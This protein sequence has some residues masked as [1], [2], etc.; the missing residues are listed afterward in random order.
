[1]LSNLIDAYYTRT[2]D[3]PERSDVNYESPGRLESPPTSGATA[4]PEENDIPQSIFPSIQTVALENKPRRELWWMDQEPKSLSLAIIAR[5]FGDHLASLPSS[6][7]SPLRRI[8]KSKARTF[9]QCPGYLREEILLSSDLAKSAIISH[10]APSAMEICSICGELVS[11]GVGNEEALRVSE[12]D[13]HLSTGGYDDYHPVP[14]P[15]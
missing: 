14:F 11:S 9:H 15:R 13:D 2:D 5:R 8:H 1:V 6:S 3:S 7:L 4:G 10:S 12:G